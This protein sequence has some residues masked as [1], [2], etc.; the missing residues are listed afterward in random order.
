MSQSL[1]LL[2]TSASTHYKIAVISLFR[3]AWFHSIH[4]NGD[5][6]FC[7]V[8]GK[9]NNWI[10]CYKKKEYKIAWQKLSKKTLFSCANPLPSRW[11]VSSFNITM[12]FK[13]Q[14][15]EINN[16]EHHLVLFNTILLYLLLSQNLN[17]TTPTVKPL[18]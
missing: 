2:I 17:K 14:L 4:N 9:Q 1:A 10:R 5:E 3:W 15:N 11:K 8:L 6:N 7:K 13:M 18:L 16:K 12:T